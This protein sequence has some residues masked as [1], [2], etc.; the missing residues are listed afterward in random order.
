MNFA[1]TSSAPFAPRNAART[2]ALF[3]SV[4]G[5]SALAQGG[6]TEGLPRIAWSVD[7]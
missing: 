5:A 3:L 7:V 6:A 4:A 2:L 1:R